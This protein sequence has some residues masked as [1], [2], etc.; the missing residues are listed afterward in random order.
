MY[1]YR[2]PPPPPQSENATLIVVDSVLACFIAGN[3]FTWDDWF[4]LETLDDSLQPTIDMLLNMSIFM[5]YGAV[6]PWDKFVENNIVSLGRLVALGILILLLRRLP[7]V[8]AIHKK[9]P[10]IEHLRQAIFVG[11]FGPV[12]VSAIFYVY[13]M[14]DFVDTLKGDDGEIRSDVAKLPEAVLVIVW[15]LCICSVV[16]TY[17]TGFPPV[18]FFPS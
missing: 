15:F 6:C 7:W 17:E 10:Q 18:Q 2:L 9:I 13:I 16:R 5:W 4:R 8:F 12:G 1:L 14:R 3:T 11:F